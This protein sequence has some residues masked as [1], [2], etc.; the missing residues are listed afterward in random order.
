MFDRHSS[1][2]GCQIINYRTDKNSTWLLLIGISAE[3]HR[4]KGNMQLYSVE[5]K[6]S[7]PIEGHAAGF[8]QMK[9]AGNPEES[10]L[11]SFAVRG[12]AGA[13]VSCYVIIE[14]VLSSLLSLSLS[15]PLPPLSLSVASCD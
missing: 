4:V 5:R 15:P 11:F 6:V 10:T 12:T 14:V 1:L 3:A 7:Q 9:L 8:A 2:A 13:K